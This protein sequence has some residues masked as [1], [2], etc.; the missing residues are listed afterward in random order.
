VGVHDEKP[1]GWIGNSY[2]VLKSFPKRARRELG[3]ALEQVQRGDE[4]SSWKPR[5]DIGPGV[6]Q[7]M[8]QGGTGSYRIFYVAKLDDVVWVLHAFQKK[9]AETSRI[10]VENGRAAYDALIRRMESQRGR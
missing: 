1:L 8:A 9:T 3:H 7:L 4:P 10:D 2:E 5:G 6:I